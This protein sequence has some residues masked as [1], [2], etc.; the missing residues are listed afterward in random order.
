MNKTK[1][2]I[3]SVRYYLSDLEK[4]RIRTL[5]SYGGFHHRTIAA[6]IFETRTPS[7][8]EIARISRVARE[9]RISTRDWRNGK[10]TDSR[11]ILNALTKHPVDS[12]PNPKSILAVLDKHRRPKL[13][14]A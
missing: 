5:L 2:V 10:T 1:R 3:T 9:S 6:R 13:K 12:K 8:A 11:S 14:I 4:M 7:D